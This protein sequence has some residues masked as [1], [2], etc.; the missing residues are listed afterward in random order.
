M[1]RNKEK[2]YIMMLKIKDNLIQIMIKTL[3]MDKLS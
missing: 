3:K 1:E 2:E